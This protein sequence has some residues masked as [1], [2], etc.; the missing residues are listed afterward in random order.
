[1]TI[2]VNADAR[3]IAQ[4]LTLPEY[5]E[6]W[7]CMPG[8]SMESHLVASQNPDGYRLDAYSDGR[9]AVRIIASYCFQHQR[10]MRLLWRKVC[11]LDYTESI[12]DFRVRGNFGASVLELNHAGFD[13]ADEYLWGQELWR[14]SLAKLTSLF[15]P[16]S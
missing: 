2:G 1:M 16:L 13:S 11:E 5:L 7:L 10:K 14:A 6:A 15:L 3:R 8:R 9:V 12:V 4:A